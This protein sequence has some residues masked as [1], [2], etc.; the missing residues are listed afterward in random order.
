MARPKTRHEELGLDEHTFVQAVRKL[1]A[2]QDRWG[3]ADLVR[4]QQVDLT[5][6]EFRSV[7]AAVAKSG[8]PQE[9]V[10]VT[11]LQRARKSTKI[12]DAGWWLAA[13]DW[14][15]AVGDY[16]KSGRGLTRREAEDS[17]RLGVLAEL[18]GTGWATAD[19]V[20]AAGGRPEA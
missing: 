20:R 1:V 7:V 4:A 5:V 13:H 8:S 3:S 6:D 17:A 11:L 2:L 15:D 9:K 19:E 14:D 10:F 12:G 16:Y 18:L